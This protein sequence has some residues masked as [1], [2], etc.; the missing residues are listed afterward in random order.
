MSKAAMRRAIDFYGSQAKLGAAIGYAQNS[1]K[2][3]NM[4]GNVSAHMAF[5]IH[6][7]TRGRVNYAD[8]L[9]VKRQLKLA[10]KRVKISMNGVGA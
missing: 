2:Y 3:A 8:L 6:A 5:Q 1:I 4:T 10:R 9:D 7:A